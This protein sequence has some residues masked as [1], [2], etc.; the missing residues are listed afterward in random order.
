MIYTLTFNPSLDY[1]LNVR[2]FAQGVVNRSLKDKYLPGGKGVNVSVVLS[3][4]GAA[5]KALGFVGGFVGDEIVRLL[6]EQGVATDFVYLDDA[7]SRINVKIKSDSETEVNAQGPEITDIHLE[8]LYQKLENITDGDT[9]VLAG[10]V[11]KGINDNIYVD[12]MKRISAKNVK[13]VVDAEGDLLMNTLPFKPF[14]IKPNNFEL[15]QIFGK[16]LTD[17]DEI[18]ECADKLREQGARNVMVSLGGDGAVLVAADGCRYYS[19]A[20]DGKLINSTGAGD[21][22]VAGFLYGYDRYNDYKKA[23]AY[24]LCSGSACAFSEKLPTKD[25]I[26]G[27]MQYQHIYDKINII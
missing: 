21:S 8:Q 6:K 27:I 26:E 4:C 1:I 5:T 14:L 11:P 19:Q 22:S 7:V 3:D 9:L 23:F 15:S 10:S 24:A 17:V 25:E 18:I 13:I 20:P 16:E 12:I 2:E